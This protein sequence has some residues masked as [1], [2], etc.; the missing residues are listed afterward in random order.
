MVY[1]HSVH[2][3]CC[4]LHYHSCT[5]T[6]LYSYCFLLLQNIRYLLSTVL[7]QWCLK[8]I[9]FPSPNPC[10]AGWGISPFSAHHVFTHFRLDTAIYALLPIYTMIQYHLSAIPV[11][12]EN[13]QTDLLCIIFSPSL[14]QQREPTAERSIVLSD[15][16]QSSSTTSCIQLQ[17]LQK[18]IVEHFYL[19]YLESYLILILQSKWKIKKH[20]VH[21][22]PH[23][24][25]WT[26]HSPGVTV[27]LFCYIDNTQP[28]YFPLEDKVP[29]E[30][31]Q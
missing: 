7:R 18:Q 27:K 22:C 20:S 23:K 9:C 5:S 24:L 19:R 4:C 13:T 11:D 21:M 30:F 15:L 3:E 31:L 16:C 12:M 2:Q 1:V 8:S 17:L 25:H 29:V 10:R 6:N 26:T 14:L 28:E